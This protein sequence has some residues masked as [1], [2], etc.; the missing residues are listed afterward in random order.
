MGAP[1]NIRKA[2]L[3]PPL[4]P[5]LIPGLLRYEMVPVHIWQKIFSSFLHDE[6][7]LAAPLVKGKVPSFHPAQGENRP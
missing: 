3:S 1:G 6:K 2:P 7:G 4:F 5:A